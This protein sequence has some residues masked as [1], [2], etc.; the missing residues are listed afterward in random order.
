M[1]TYEKAFTKI[2]LR[3]SDASSNAN[4]DVVPLMVKWQ[5][6]A[7]D[8]FTH[9]TLNAETEISENIYEFVSSDEMFKMFEENKSVGELVNYAIAIKNK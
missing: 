1:N 7:R 6:A 5:E 8:I 3:K 4:I 9:L 2:N